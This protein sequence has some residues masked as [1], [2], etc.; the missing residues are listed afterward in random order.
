MELNTI[1][2]QNEHLE[3]KSENGINIKFQNIVYRARRELSLNR[4][5]F[6]KLTIQ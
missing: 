4:C 6:K 2:A 5:K 1:S 3:S